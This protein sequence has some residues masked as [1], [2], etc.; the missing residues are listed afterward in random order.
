MRLV[1]KNQ[2][3][4]TVIKMIN[5]AGEYSPQPMVIIQGYHY[6]LATLRWFRVLLLF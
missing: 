2:K 3:S 5:A 4:I 1:L 6:P